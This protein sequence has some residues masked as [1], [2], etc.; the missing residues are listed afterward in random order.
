MLTSGPRLALRARRRKRL[1][2]VAALSL[3]LHLTILLLVLAVVRLPALPTEPPSVEIMV[4]AGPPEAAKQPA[5]SPAMPAEALPAA[6]IPTDA[7]PPEPTQPPAPEVQPPTPEAP[8]PTPEAQAPPPP[9]PPDQTQVAAAEPPPPPPPPPPQAKPPPPAARP[10]PPPRKVTAR[11]SP[12]P[13]P[14][15]ARPATAAAREP[16]P[17]SQAPSPATAPAPLLEGP[18]TAVHIEGAQLGPDWIRQLQAWWDRHAFFPGEAASK[19][20]SG[21]VKVQLIV[22]PDG[23]VSTIHVIQGAG[24]KQIDNAAYVAFRG[25]HLHP[26]PPGTPAPQADVTITLHYVLTTGP[27]AAA[28]AVKHPF[29]VTNKPVEGTVVATLPSHERTCTGRLVLDSPGEIDSIRGSR[30]YIQ[31]VFY[32]APDGKPRVKVTT[33]FGVI[34]VAVSES[35]GSAAWQGP[36]ERKTAY[37]M[38]MKH[39]YIWPAGPDH[40]TGSLTNS[41][42]P[43]ADGTVDLTCEQGP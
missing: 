21:T 42:N 3:G 26:F 20:L 41:F 15:P 4:D 2:G 5:P 12:R 40:A 24:T 30:G 19:G 16:S 38:S 27:A 9:P 1:A 23:E 22:L 39:F 10:P 25:A 43:Q 29:T 33:S 31:A 35:D 8:P 6:A 32:R 34:D 17:A 13:A 14:A 18:E 7:A 36:L 11:P 37:E 28:A